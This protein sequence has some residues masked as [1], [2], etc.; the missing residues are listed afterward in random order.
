LVL[1]CHPARFI[2]MKTHKTASTSVEMYFERFCVPPGRFLGTESV[3]QILTETGVVGGR[4]DGKRKGDLWYNH[5]AAERVRDLVGAETWARYFKFSTVRNPYGQ[6]VSNFF[7]LT[8]RRPPSDDAGFAEAR[9]AFARFV[10]GPRLWRRKWSNDLHI[11]GIDGK[12]AM[13]RLIRFEYLE[14]DMR[15]VCTHLGLPFEA[16]LLP[17]TKRARPAGK[18]YGL[19]EYYTP[20]LEAIVRREFDWL[21]SRLDYRL[22]A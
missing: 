21:I 12:V 1:V 22:A 4:R 11:V 2:F 20:E 8:H 3:P 14:A 9:R 17:H 13:D 16:S 5:M 6:M 19:A 18:R 10:K 7:W 15:D